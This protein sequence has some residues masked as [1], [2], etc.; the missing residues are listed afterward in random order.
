[1]VLGRKRELL[2]QVKSLGLV[3]DLNSLLLYA[4]TSVQF[5]AMEG[6]SSRTE[7]LYINADRTD[8]VYRTE[9]ANCQ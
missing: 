3:L 1:M 8:H 4:P 6:N 7:I 9:S 5:Y 2:Q